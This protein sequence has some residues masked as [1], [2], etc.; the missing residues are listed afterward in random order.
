MKIA[1]IFWSGTGNTKSMAE[2][3]VLG[4]KNGAEVDIFE[5]CEFKK[6]DVSKYDAFAFGCP[7]MGA[8][9]L[10]SDEFEPMFS[11]IEGELK[12]KKV[13]LFGSYDWGDGEWMR[14]WEARTKAVGAD[15]VDTLIVNNSPSDEDLGK[16]EALGKALI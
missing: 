9:E 11:S 12:G 7:A 5:A 14:L 10:E 13:V 4:A 16:S 1:V 3:V 8:E 6:D 15:V 2:S